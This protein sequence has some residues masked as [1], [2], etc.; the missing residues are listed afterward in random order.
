MNKALPENIK[1]K[2]LFRFDK[3]IARP[4][5]P[6]EIKEINDVFFNSDNIIFKDGKILPASFINGTLEYY[7][8]FPRVNFNITK[9]YLGWKKF[10]ADP[11]LLTSMFFKKKIIIT[12]PCLC[13][14][15]TWSIGYFHWL[16]DALP[17]LITAEKYIDQTLIVL[18]A[19]YKKIGYVAESLKIFG[20]KNIRWVENGE[21]L[22]I[23]KLIVPN[24]LAPS[25]NYDP[26]IMQKLIKKLKN[27]QT[28]QRLNLGDKIYLSRQ[29][30]RRRKIKNEREILPIFS[31]YGF[32][33]IILEN[34]KW[35]DQISICQNA[36]Y[37][38]SNHG[39][40]LANLI[41]MGEGGKILELG[42]GQNPFYC[43]FS[44]AQ[45]VNLRYY[46]QVCG[47]SFSLSK[48]D[49]HKNNLIV[50]AEELEKN[51]KLMLS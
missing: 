16:L 41:F 38:T 6:H 19:K 7:F 37:L 2:D 43:F 25:G 22:L 42:G 11:F 9:R 36:R 49:N 35:E 50:N 40:G 48:K 51:I 21:I 23:K 17:R 20:I 13:F 18:P 15:D 47:Y 3:N 33:K 46:Y 27:Y 45:K 30:A 24:H 31:K 1:E 10:L 28:G 4:I 12:E 32:K 26:E 14:T 29:K 44:L 8:K 5:P 39:A 34:Y